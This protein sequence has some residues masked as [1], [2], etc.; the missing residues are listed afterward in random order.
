[1]RVQGCRI[2]GQILRAQVTSVTNQEQI[3]V[4]EDLLLGAYTFIIVMLLNWPLY[5]YVR[6]LFIPHYS[7]I[8]S[9]LYVK[10]IQWLQL[11]FGYVCMCVFLYPFTF[12]LCF[13]IKSRIL[14]DSI[15]F[16]L[17]KKI[18]SDNICLFNWCI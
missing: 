17:F 11:P 15:E 6:S 7:L 16:G 1:L 2:C 3:F 5:H 8:W 14:E 10:L 9:L 18:L 4:F 13:Y 12:N